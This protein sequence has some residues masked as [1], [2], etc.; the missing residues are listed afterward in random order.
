MA[1]TEIMYIH[2][3]NT[4]KIRRVIFISLG[5]Y[6]CNNK[7]QRT[8]AMNSKESNEGMRGEVESGNEMSE[9]A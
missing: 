4:K 7:T 5:V 6:I 2:I 3:S 1:C 9:M 8:K